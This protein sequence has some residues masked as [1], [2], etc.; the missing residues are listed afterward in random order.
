MAIRNY[1]QM[2]TDLQMELSK[3][4]ETI[5]QLDSTIQETLAAVGDV[6]WSAEF[7]EHYASNREHIQRFEES[8]DVYTQE[9]LP[10]AIHFIH[11][12]EQTYHT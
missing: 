2:M 10:H 9:I 4:T 11:S 5:R 8:L 7:K 12:I 1:S 6:D 3:Y